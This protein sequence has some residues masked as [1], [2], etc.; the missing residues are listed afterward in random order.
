MELLAA[1]QHTGTPTRLIDG[2]HHAL[3]AAWYA[4]KDGDNDGRLFALEV[5]QRELSQQSAQDLEVFWRNPPP[6]WQSEFWVWTPAPFEERM[7]RQHG[8]LLVGGIPKT[9]PPRWYLRGQIQNR[10]TE[11]QVRRVTSIAAWASKGGR[12]RPATRPIRT[13]RIAKEAKETLRWQLD[14]LFDLSE[15]TLYPRSRR[16]RGPCSTTMAHRVRVMSEFR[17]E[18][19]Q[20]GARYGLEYLGQNLTLAALEGV[21]LVG[22]HGDEHELGRKDGSLIMLRADLILKAGMTAG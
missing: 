3:A 9:P 4:C 12:G 21:L 19:L 20:I 11:Q 6:N 17:A 18:S 8:A 22:V 5:S 2:T 16:I 15:R 10:Y 7:A 13:F 14:V 1:L